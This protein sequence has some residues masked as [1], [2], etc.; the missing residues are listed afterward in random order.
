MRKAQ[1][2]IGL[3]IAVSVV[4]VISK[5]ATGSLNPMEV[6]SGD[7]LFLKILVGFFLFMIL[8]QIIGLFF[9]P[10]KDKNCSGCGND[11]T[12]F[13]YSHGQPMKCPMCKRLYHRKCY[14]EKAEGL[15]SGCKRD[16][17]PSAVAQY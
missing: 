17:C 7:S 2:I 9:N 4:L 8:M 14:M 15:L 10:Y 16:G 12:T 3:I 5:L 13:V 6:F 1:I 11:L